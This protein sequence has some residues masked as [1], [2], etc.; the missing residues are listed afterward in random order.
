MGFF[1]EFG[2]IVS[3]AIA[4][5]H[6]AKASNQV[7]GARDA[8]ELAGICERGDALCAKIEA[9]P[10]MTTMRARGGPAADNLDASMTI[11]KLSM[12]SAFT[13]A[14]REFEPAVELSMSCAD[15][16]HANV[17]LVAANTGLDAFAQA[18]VAARRSGGLEA[19]GAR[20]ATT[21]QLL[22]ALGAQA[23]GAPASAAETA[24]KPGADGAQ[25][26]KEAPFTVD[27]KPTDAKLGLGMAL[28]FL[29]FEE[30][31]L[32][33][34]RAHVALAARAHGAQKIVEREI[35]GKGSLAWF[36]GSIDQPALS[37]FRTFLAA[38]LDPK[39][40]T[41]ASP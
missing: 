41:R 1:K 22:L 9:N 39:P 36:Y 21:R 29:A 4:F 17:R 12:R 26:F 15:S 25:S 3:L 2:S 19:F 16:P 35:Q 30:G 6:L 27:A 11:M 20:M 31:R 13:I 8:E 40:A 38:E 23:M 18:R 33:E 28:A 24:P 14:L 34:A 10:T 5:R 37:E 32:P 7:A